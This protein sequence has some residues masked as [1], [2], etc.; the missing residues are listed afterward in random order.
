[1]VVKMSIGEEDIEEKRILNL[2][3][4]RK[5]S[6]KRVN[7]K[8]GIK[9]LRLCDQDILIIVVLDLVVKRSLEW[10]D[11][12]MVFLLFC[13]F[14][15]DMKKFILIMKRKRLDDKEQNEIVRKRIKFEDVDFEKDYF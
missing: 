10:D 6:R 9:N 13:L 8:V 12:C 7:K 14:L 3:Q 4:L 1:M 2:I 11:D 15:L 5:N